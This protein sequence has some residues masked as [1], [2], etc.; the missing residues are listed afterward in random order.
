MTDSG[1]R[2]Q[3]QRKA[4]DAGPLPAFPCVRAEPG[5]DGSEDEVGRHVD[6]VDAAAR[7]VGCARAVRESEDAGLVADLRSL[8]GSIHDEHADDET[9]D[10][11]AEDPDNSPRQDE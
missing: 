7:A 3:Y 4:A 11:I 2:E 9:R 6:G 1:K 8:R 5:A 10:V